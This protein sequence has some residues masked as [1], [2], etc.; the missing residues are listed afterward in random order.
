MHTG[1]VQGVLAGASEEGSARERRRETSQVRLHKDNDTSSI[2]TYH[3]SK[4]PAMGKANANHLT[5][6]TLGYDHGFVSN[7]KTDAS[8]DFFVRSKSLVVGLCE[9]RETW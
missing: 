4:T 3:S 5:Y 8:I 2:C 1:E 9:S 7:A 6:L